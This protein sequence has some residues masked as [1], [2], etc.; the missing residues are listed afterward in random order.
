M[1]DI[2]V[3]TLPSGLRVV[4]D[5]IE[6]VRSASVGLW[7]GAGTRNEA[8]EV[9]GVAHL[10]EHMVFKGTERRNA[11]AIA[12]A[13]ETVGGHMNAFTSREVTAFYSRVLA[14]D[15]PLAMD[16]TADILQNSLFDA[17]ELARERSVVLQEIGQANDT[18]DDIIFDHFQTAAFP[19]QGLGRP[20]LGLPD[21]VSSLPREAI[22]AYLRQHYAGPNMVLSASGLVE[23]DRIVE[24]AAALFGDLPSTPAVPDTPARYGGGE[25]RENKD[26]EQ[27]H[28][29]L[30]FD[31]VGYH[32]P[33]FHAMNVLATLLGG[34]MSSRLF[35]EIREK[36]GLVYTIHSFSSSY[37]DSG[38]FGVYAGTGGEDATELVPVLCDQLMAV[39]GEVTDEEVERARAQLRAGLVMGME[40][41]MARCEQAGQQMLIYGRVLSMEEQLE[42][43]AAVD[44]TAVRRV[45]T[46]LLSSRPTL[47]ALGPASAL[48]SYDGIAG[49]LRHAA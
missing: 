27:L 37:C 3:T 9:N 29:L 18:P 14:E 30:G 5:H 20:V 49:R 12:E 1:T 15:V 28:L 23:H 32:D 22:I 45:A 16:V 8:P 41:T 25:Y 47:G 36:R 11:A 19:D 17:E 31:G 46:R 44:A 42:S 24:Q 48:E 33:D 10:L 4:T 39:T 7:V 2:K 6:T 34:G 35:Q 26:L 43:L 13:L 21:V 40:S 38:L